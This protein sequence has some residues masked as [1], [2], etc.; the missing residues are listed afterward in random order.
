MDK[1]RIDPLK[2]ISIEED[3][4]LVEKIHILWT[5]RSQITKGLTTVMIIK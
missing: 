5:N 4:I 2:K 1:N 3:N